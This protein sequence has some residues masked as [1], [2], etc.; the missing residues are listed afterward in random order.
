MPANYPLD[1]TGL[2]PGNLITNENHVLTEV[3]SDAYRI[4]IPVFAPFYLDNFSLKHLLPTGETQTL[5][6]D[7]DYYMCLPYMGASRSIGKMIYGAISINT[8]LVEG[9]LQVTYQTLGGEWVGDPGYVRERLAEYTFNPRMTLW[10]TVTNKPNQ[11]PPINHQ[12]DFDTVYGQQELIAS[13]NA[14]AQQIATGPNPNLPIIRHL[15]D[16]ENPHQ[17][18]KAQVGLSDV[19]NYPVATD[20]EVTDRTEVDKY[21]TLRQLIQFP[22]NDP[23]LVAALQQALSDHANDTD[24]PHQVTKDQVGLGNVSNLPVATALEV[25]E[26]V[27]ANKY[28]M[29]SQV[30]QL[31]QNYQQNNNGGST[32][33]Y[34]PRLTAASYYLMG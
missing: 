27:P 1:P 24:N 20:Q 30:L 33:T 13:I 31:L 32:N 29:L 15:T 9:I 7:V 3:N 22:L 17:V 6:P 14:L 34:K 28:V 21:V 25:S 5:Q 23:A 26:S 2:S 10:D 12:Q 16:V 4:L 11:F 19:L 8:Q 18:T